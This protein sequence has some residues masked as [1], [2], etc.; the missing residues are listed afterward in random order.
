M[1]IT[2]LSEDLIN[3]IAAGEVV[4]RPAH[5]LK[6]LLENSI[7]AGAT[8]IEVDLG[9]GARF[10]KVKDNGSGIAAAELPLALER[11]AT[12]KIKN[13]EDLWQINS[14]GFRGEALASAASV[15]ELT[16][17]SRP[18]N[19]EV[20]ATVKVD[21]GKIQKTESAGAAPGTT[22]IVDKLFENIPAR[23]KFLK[24]DSAE[25]AQA[26]SVLKATAMA[27][28]EVALRI[29][30]NNELAFYWPAVQSRCERVQNVL[31]QTAM[32]EA[33]AEV[34]SV[35]A[36]VIACSPN[37]TFPQS[38]KIYIFVKNR[39]VQDRGLQT[40]VID[41]YRTLLMHGEYPI[42]AVFLD[43]PA[44]E[45]DVNIHPTKSQ[46]KFRDSGLAFRAVHRATRDML[47]KGPWLGEMLNQAPAAQI[48][49]VAE[50]PSYSPTMFNALEL[51][52]TQFKTPVAP[53][54][55]QPSSIPVVPSTP[56]L[57]TPT[58][59]AWNNL[60]IIGQARLT[61][62]MAQ[63][64]R[65]LIIVDQHAAHERVNFERLM[66]GFKEGQFEV[67]NFLLPI[68]IDLEEHLLEKLVP[69]FAQIEQ[70]LGIG[71]DQIGPAT[72]GVRAAIAFIKE[73]SLPAAVIKM[74]EEIFEKGESFALEKSVGEIFATM[75]CHSSIRAGHALSSEE[76]RSLLMQ[77]D[78][79]SMSSFCPHGRP[80]FVEYPFS[81]LERDFGRTV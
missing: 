35:K 15:S 6:E 80:V 33:F 78:E 77:M 23:K 61:Y 17:I 45:V 20:G 44:N 16:V 31:E 56:L 72:V 32:F 63:N 13:I 73:E 24:S 5:L 68:T 70:R 65:A 37:V 14:F 10:I 75:A 38:K 36:H 42:A 28:P 39:P 7:D 26:K 55:V 34:S 74:A 67:Q 41:A 47:E 66:R 54:F 11:H 62:I 52:R 19:Q 27:N 71:L 2:R 12:S 18:P 30:I 25:I 59:S 22:V 76:M 9:D 50:T 58:P 79:F 81:Q 40:A 46:V 53:T 1:A 69:H 43:C 3:Q 21:F 8:E 51:Q 64:E 49:S 60:Q 29:K 48:P 4:E 57:G